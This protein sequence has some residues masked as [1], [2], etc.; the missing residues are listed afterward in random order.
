MMPL[1]IFIAAFGSLMIGIYTFAYWLE[2]N[3]NYNSFWSTIK[4]H[5][6]IGSLLGLMIGIVGVLIVTI[7]YMLTK[8]VLFIYDKVFCMKIFQIKIFKEGKNDIDNI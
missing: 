5:L 6:T 2:L 1:L 4:H 7:A 3:T 8:I